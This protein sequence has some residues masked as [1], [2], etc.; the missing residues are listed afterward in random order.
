MNVDEKI[1]LFLELINCNY[2]LNIWTYDSELTLLE[3]NSPPELIISDIN[4]FLSAYEPLIEYAKTGLYPYI[5][6]IPIGILWI[7]DFERQNGILH[8]I[9]LL[10]PVFTGNHS[11]NILRQKLDY[12]D[13]SVKI[14]SQIFKLIDLIPIIPTNMLYQYAIMLHYCLTGDKITSQDIQYSFNKEIKKAYDTPVKTDDH[15]GIW[16]AEQALVKMFREGNP[17]YKIE[18]E[19]SSLLSHGIKFDVGDSIRQK[20]NSLMILL[21]LCSRATIDG[22][23]SPSV[24]FTLCDYYTQCIEE[25]A[26]ITELTNVSRTMLDDYM[27]RLRQAKEHPNVSTQIHDCCSYISMHVNEKISIRHLADRVGY[28]EYYFSRKFKS[29][30]GCSVNDYIK[31]EKIEKAKLLLSSTQLSIQEIS[32]ELN[33]CSRSHFSDLFKKLTDMSPSDYREKNLKL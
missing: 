25:A 18:L 19:K 13:L 20:K 5:L 2:Q 3:T 16:L 31:K 4:S 15:R 23:L 29:E 21:T 30:M 17:G 32:D 24:S 22:G 14:K 7:V 6:E 33:F 9:H 8:K 10:G 11:Y 12:K 28:T 1:K 26:T 27:D